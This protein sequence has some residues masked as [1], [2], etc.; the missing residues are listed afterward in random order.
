MI[1]LLSSMLAS[2]EWNLLELR[3]VKELGYVCVEVERTRERRM[4]KEQEIYIGFNSCHEN[5]FGF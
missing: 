2:R 4:R 5:S 3:G 1:C